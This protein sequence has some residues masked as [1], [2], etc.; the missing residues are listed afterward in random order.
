MASKIAKLRDLTTKPATAEHQEEYDKQTSAKADDRSFCL[1]LAA[2][3]ENELDRAI[4]HWLGELSEKI[5]HDMYDRDGPLGNFS[6]K[7]TLASA[8]EIIGPTSQEN[9]RLVRNIRN[10]FAH[11]KVPLTFKTTEV[12]AVCADLK[13]INIF[14][15]PVEV[16]QAPQ[17]PARARFETVC[18]ET[19]VRLARY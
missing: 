19:M 15:P 2:M 4:D 12:S 13:R 7:I 5:R 6:R 14:N 16:D 17:M 9:F 1:L 3:L 10:A 8:L 18:N 11:A